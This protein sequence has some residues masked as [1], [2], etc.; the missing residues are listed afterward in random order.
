MLTLRAVSGLDSIPVG[1]PFSEFWSSFFGLPTFL[2]PVFLGLVFLVAS[3]AFFT[4][5]GG[6]PLGLS[7]GLVGFFDVP[8]SSEKLKKL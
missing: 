5:L 2:T 8:A 4:E 7:P 1:L 3:F 6:L